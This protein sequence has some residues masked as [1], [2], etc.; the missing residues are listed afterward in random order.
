VFLGLEEHLHGAPLNLQGSLFGDTC[1]TD[2]ET[3]AH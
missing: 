1:L 3:E 2:V